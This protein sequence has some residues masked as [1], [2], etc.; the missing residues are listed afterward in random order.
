LAK[1]DVRKMTARNFDL[2]TEKFS[3]EIDE[4]LA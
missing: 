1:Q 3:G 4:F 2:H